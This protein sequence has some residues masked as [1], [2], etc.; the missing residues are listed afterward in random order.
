MQRGGWFLAG[1]E[2]TSAQMH[3]I[4]MKLGH[5]ILYI[6]IYTCAKY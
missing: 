6:K 5:L 3:C 4:A 2:N 1:E